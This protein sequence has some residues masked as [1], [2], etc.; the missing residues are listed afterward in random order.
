[1]IA[2]LLLPFLCK[3]PGVDLGLFVIKKGRCHFV[4][5][6]KGYVQFQLFRKLWR[7]RKETFGVVFEPGVVTITYTQNSHPTPTEI[8]LKIQLN[9]VYLQNCSLTQTSKLLCHANHSYV[10]SLVIIAC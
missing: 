2:R 9:L 5:I 1:M 7:G 8:R 6:L 10:F 3:L 4:G